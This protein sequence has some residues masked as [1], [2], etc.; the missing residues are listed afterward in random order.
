MLSFS[1]T[2]QS[3]VLKAINSTKSDISNRTSVN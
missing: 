3:D 2:D 1:D